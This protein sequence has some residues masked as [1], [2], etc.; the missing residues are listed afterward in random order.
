[1]NRLVCTGLYGRKML[2]S[3]DLYL[4]RADMAYGDRLPFDV[5]YSKVKNVY[6]VLHAPGIDYSPTLVREVPKD[7]CY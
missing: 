5:F 4:S 7:Y 2:F 1:M 3:K 6:P